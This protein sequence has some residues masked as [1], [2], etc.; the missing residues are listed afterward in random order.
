MNLY[1]IIAKKK[2]DPTGHTEILN[3]KLATRLTIILISLCVMIGIAVWSAPASEEDAQKP[4]HHHVVQK[5]EK[6]TPITTNTLPIYTCPLP[7]FLLLF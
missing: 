6:E 7:G 3:S 2:M 5:V 1:P 4:C